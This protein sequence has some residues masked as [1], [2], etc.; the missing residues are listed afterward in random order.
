VLGKVFLRSIYRGLTADAI[1]LGA[2]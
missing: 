1:D 2:G